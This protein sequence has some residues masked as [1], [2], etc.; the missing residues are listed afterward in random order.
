MKTRSVCFLLL[1]EVTAM[2]LW[3]VSAAILPEMSKVASLSPFQEAA[4][5]SGV[6]A[7]FVIGA[8]ALA[9]IGLP[10]RIDP[11]IVFSASAIAAGS[12]NLC[13]LVVDPASWTAIAVRVATGALLAGVYP[14]GMKIIVGWGLQD[15]G[16][17]VGAL[18]SALA[19]GSA[20]PH[21]IALLGGTDWQLTVI[22]TSV[23]A[24]FAGLLCIGISLGPHHAKAAR[25]D[26]SV[27]P[28]AWRNRRVRLAYAGYLGHMFEMF[29]MWA[30]IGVATATSYT[31]TMPS[32][33]A[34]DLAKLTAF[35]AIGVS[36]LTCVTA[37]YYADRWGKAEI[38]MIAMVIS[39]ISAVLTGLSFGGPAWITFVLVVIWGLSV[40]P[41]SAQFSA[42]VADAAPPEQVGSL[43]TLQTALGFALTVITVQLTPVLASAV[44]WSVVLAG[45]AIGP[46]LG[47]IAMQR[48]REM[49]G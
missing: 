26:P 13:L 35:A 4:L 15:R 21:L 37:G 49:H 22:A 24:I 43:M 12:I 39:G 36:C 20:S 34:A 30:W 40:A 45:L 1:A 28:T 27:V 18:T 3:F 31:L 11:R 14:V 25:F 2:S 10:D 42:L 44:S 5:S 9:V 23:A 19:L 38:A 47:V 32:A 46:L 17:L 16:F 8:L 6:Q 7:G 33:E 29:A 41:D 48:L